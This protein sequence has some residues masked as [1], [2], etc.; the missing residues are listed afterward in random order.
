[1]DDS[2]RVRLREAIRLIPDHH[3]MLGRDTV[4]VQTKRFSIGEMLQ[5][6]QRP[7]SLEPLYKLGLSAI[8]VSD[9]IVS[10]CC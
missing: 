8:T 5:N 9:R 3:G 2:H 4:R 1:M 6:L 10:D 7:G